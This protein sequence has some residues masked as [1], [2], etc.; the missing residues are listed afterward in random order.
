LQF[1]GYSSRLAHSDTRQTVREA[2]SDALAIMAKT[3]D[4]TRGYMF[5][6]LLHRLDNPCSE[7]LPLIAKGMPEHISS[8][9]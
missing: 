4:V 7:A 3:S 1:R 6:A 9:P 5:P 8:V 2:V